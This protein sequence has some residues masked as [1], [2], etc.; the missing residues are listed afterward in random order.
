M[1]SFLD[2]S[3]KP[4]PTFSE[5]FYETPRHAGFY[6]KGPTC[7]LPPDARGGYNGVVAGN[8]ITRAGRA[9]PEP[10]YRTI[11]SATAQS[12][13]RAAFGF[14]PSC[15][16]LGSA[17]AIAGLGPNAQSLQT[18][19]QRKGLLIHFRARDRF[20]ML[21][22]CLN[23]PPEVSEPFIRQWIA[24]LDGSHTGESADGPTKHTEQSPHHELV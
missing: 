10:D 6:R 4:R 5:P 11:K 12:S 7:L 18:D 22:A 16:M 17:T 9:I 8:A 23:M 20:R 15:E 24:P 19:G 1:F 3:S 2:G 14:R 13:A 21:Q